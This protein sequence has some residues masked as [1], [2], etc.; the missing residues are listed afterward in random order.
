MSR[1]VILWSL[2]SPICLLIARIPHS[3]QNYWHPGYPNIWASTIIYLFYWLPL[4]IL[5]GGALLLRFQ[6]KKIAYMWFF[7]TSMTGLLIMLLH[8]LSLALMNIDTRGQ[9]VIILVI[10]LPCLA[11]VGG[12]VLGLAQ[13]FVIRSHYKSGLN[14]PRLNTLWFL[15]SFL[16]W[17]MGFV[18]VL[19]FFWTQGFF[20]NGI[21][22]VL[23]IFVALGGWMKGWFIQ[24][25]LQA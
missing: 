6:D 14:L 18:G 2:I 21:L 20:F 19:V 24:K 10:S 16:S 23:A 5:Q 3:F 17:I 15:V 22:S 9:G 25:Y 8:D 7:I 1:F 12:P 13:F 11:L 4:G